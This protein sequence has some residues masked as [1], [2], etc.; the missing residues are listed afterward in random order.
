MIKTRYLNIILAINLTLLSV[1][2]MQVL[3][4]N[5]SYSEP[6]IFDRNLKAELVASD[7]DHPTSMAFIGE[8]DILVLE[9]NNGKVQ[10][11]I[12]GEKQERPILDLN[13]ANKYERGL[14]GIAT[15]PEN[16]L[17]KTHDDQQKFVF[18]FYTESKNDGNDKCYSATVCDEDTNPYGNRLYRYELDNDKL[19][20]PKLLLDLPAAPGADHI[21]GSIAIGPDNN[22]YVMSGDGDS[23]WANDCW[24]QCWGNVCEED[25]EDS[26][27]N[28]ITLNNEDGKP[29]DGRGGI[30]RLTM[31]GWSV[32]GVIL[33]TEYP[34]NLYYAYGFRNGFGM[35]FD[36]ITGNLWITEN[37]PGFG[38]EINLVEP[39]FNSGWMK[40]GG[41]WPVDVSNSNPNPLK[42][43]GYFGNEEFSDFDNLVNLNNNGKYSEPEFIWNSSVG[44]T[45]LKFFDSKQMGNEYLNDLF[46]ADYNNNYIYNFNLNYA[47]TGLEL[48]DS[49]TDKI[50]NTNEELDSV[51][52]AKDFGVIT[53]MDIGSDGYLYLLSHTE[54]KIYRI[55]PK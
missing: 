29:A 38:D 42:G 36:P 23:C 16:I 19:V 2:V 20:N 26:V 8:N 35:D 3:F 44:V 1:I 21:S 31:D 7:L 4:L 13:V 43:R 15:Y 51:V 34:L 53:D 39:G 28:S 27:A 14:L 33:G 47:R 46:V 49:L 45:A 41:I 48:E 32:P 40:V 11:I 24:D 25:F 12:N 10:R 52:F 30:L 50:A 18:L 54:G 9:K 5:P 22:I 6:I 37:G 17:D 55:I